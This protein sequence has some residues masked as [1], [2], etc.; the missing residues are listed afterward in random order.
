MSSVVPSGVVVVPVHHLA[1]CV[2]A[3]VWIRVLLNLRKRRRRCFFRALR[4]VYRMAEIGLTTLCGNRRDD[5]W[6]PGCG[7]AAMAERAGVAALAR[8]TA[9]RKPD[10]RLSGC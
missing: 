2:L 10:A 8:S 9:C 3:C 6:L 5:G 4:S 7:L 1:C